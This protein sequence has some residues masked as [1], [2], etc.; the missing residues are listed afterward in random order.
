MLKLISV[1]MEGEKH[2][3]RILS[4]IHSENP[5]IICFQ[6]CPESFKNNL[7][8]L[9]YRSDFLPMRYCIQNDVEYI[10]GL[11]FASKLQFA[12]IH[13]YYYQPDYDLPKQPIPTPKPSMHHGYILATLEHNGQLYH[14]ATT[15]VMWTPDGM[16]TEHQT[17][18][19]KK[20]LSLLQSEKAHI[21]CGDFN[22]PRN[23]NPLYEEIVKNYTDT[24]PPEYMSSLDPTL[25]RL[26]KVQ[27]L[28]APIFD[29]YMVDYLFSKPDFA[30]TGVRL[31]FGI[32][33]HAAIVATIAKIDPEHR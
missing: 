8:N 15:H 24:I 2:F 19:V 1:N 11:V 25:H 29:R 7:H 22:M 13:K 12:S 6:E 10:E 30:V 17:Q 9:G 20:L 26:A 18:G 33:D 5:D 14:I 27:D 16:P 21:I 4:L 3:P 23:V 32:S 28:N 31:Q